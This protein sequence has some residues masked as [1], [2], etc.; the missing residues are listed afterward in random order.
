MVPI[1]TLI[2]KVATLLKCA[3]EK[4]SKNFQALLFSLVHLVTKTHM[5]ANLEAIVKHVTA[6]NLSKKFPETP[7]SIIISPATNSKENTSI[8]T[9]DPVMTTE[10]SHHISFKRVFADQRYTVCRMS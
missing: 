2:A 8:W 7:D 3:V 1:R 9:A 6:K 4:N 10:I 5:Q